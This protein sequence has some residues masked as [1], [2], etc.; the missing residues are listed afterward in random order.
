MRGRWRWQLL[1]RGGD[2]ADL[3]RDVPL[4]KGW[5]IDVDPVSMLI[6][7]VPLV[8]LFELSIVLASLFGQPGGRA[9]PTAP[10]AEGSGQA[11]GG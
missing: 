11:A 9:A 1:L 4:P 10:S 5:A 8:L 7:T 6:E 2:P 3:I